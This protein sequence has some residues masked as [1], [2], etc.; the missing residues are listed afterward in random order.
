MA[1][2]RFK[3]RSDFKATPLEEKHLQK[4][5]GGIRAHDVRPDRFLYANHNT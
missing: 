3:Y 4:N 2:P 5:G 1:K